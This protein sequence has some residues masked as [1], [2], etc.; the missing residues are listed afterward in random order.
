MKVKGTSRGI[1]RSGLIHHRCKQFCEILPISLEWKIK[2]LHH[3]KTF[4]KNKSVEFPSCSYSRHFVARLDGW[5]WLGLFWCCSTYINN[6]KKKNNTA[7]IKFSGEVLLR[8]AGGDGGVGPPQARRGVFWSVS[9]LLVV[10]DPPDP[11]PEPPAVHL[12]ET[13]SPQAHLRIGQEV[14]YVLFYLKQNNCIC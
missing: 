7:K 13:P 1:K 3:L 4:W 2:T 6:N 9:R 8:E 10:S 12:Q 5:I 11:D 14:L